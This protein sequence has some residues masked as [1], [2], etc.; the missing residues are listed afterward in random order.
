MQPLSQSP[1][2]P[3]LD[4]S[5]WSWRLQRLMLTPVFRF[6]LR[7]GLP[8]FFT[9]GVGVNYFSD[10]ARQAAITDFIASTRASIQERPEFMVSLMAIDGAD[11][12]LAEDI[13]NNLSID[14]PVSSFDLDLDEMRETLMLLSPVA[15][16]SMSIR[17]GGVLQVDVVSGAHVSHISFRSDRA[18][19]P[20]IAGE[21]ANEHVG[22][23]MELIRTAQPLGKRLRGVVRMGARRWDVVLDRDQRIL[24]PTIGAVSALER[25]IAL[26][27]AQ[28]VLSRDVASIDMR[29]G[30]RPTV[31]INNDATKE[32]RSSR[33]LPEIGR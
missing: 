25:V 18:E 22:E 7:V 12:D 20:L 1:K 11:T 23:A 14:F 17:S 2:T 4:P 32:A 10:H 13:R 30:G 8:V 9:F 33:Q 29:L 31:K 6:G 27:G 16:A 24:L 5:R 28:D 19:L 21:G 15:E 3:R 26:D